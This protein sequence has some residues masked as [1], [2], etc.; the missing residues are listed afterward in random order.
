[1]SGWLILISGAMY[2]YVALEQWFFKGNGPM[3]IIYSG[4]AF[5]NIGLYLM[6]SK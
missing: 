4:Y 3:L 1:M 6:A 5:S 2:A